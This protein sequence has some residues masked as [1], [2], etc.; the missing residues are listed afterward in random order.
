M[1][2]IRKNNGVP[3]DPYLHKIVLVGDTET[4]SA[5]LYNVFD[6][7]DKVEIV[8]KV[9]NSDSCKIGSTIPINI[10]SESLHDIMFSVN[11]IRTFPSLHCQ[12]LRE[13]TFGAHCCDHSPYLFLSCLEVPHLRKLVF[14]SASFSGATS[15]I[16]RNLPFLQSITVNESAFSPLLFQSYI[17]TSLILFAHILELTDVEKDAFIAC[18]SGQ[19]ILDNLP[20][21]STLFLTDGCF[22]AYHV[23]HFTNL[24]LLTSLTTENSC[25][26]GVQSLQLNSDALRTVSLGPGSFRFT[27]R[28][29]IKA[30]GL[31]SFV[32]DRFC[33]HEAES[34][35]WTDLPHLQ[36]IEIGYKAFEK[37]KVAEIR[38]DFCADGLNCRL[39]RAEKCANRQVL[40]CQCAGVRVG[41]SEGVAVS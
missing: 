36:S 17:R 37:S 35:R 22:L 29:E 15:C 27:K 20:S 24:P 34:A 33:F 19:L 6:I 39:R 8:L 26:A 5:C 25:F 30:A 21:L 16:I 32:V 28:L 38:S 11:S 23:V 18:H 13:L 40:L 4:I 2:N 10:I 3:L 41:R 1:C 14:E 9:I 12:Q 7:R 31:T